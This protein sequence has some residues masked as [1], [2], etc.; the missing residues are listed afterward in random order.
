M[1]QPPSR[2]LAVLALILSFVPVCWIAQ[3]AAIVMAVIHLAKPRERTGARRLAVAAIPIAIIMG[4]AQLGVLILIGFAASH[5]QAHR[6]A[7]GAVTQA[8]FVYLDELHIGDCAEKPAAS[9]TA[10]LKVVPCTTPHTLEV[11]ATFD[12]PPGPY[13]GDDDVKR[14]AHGGC[15]E[16]FAAYVGVTADKTSVGYL[17]YHPTST[18]WGGGRNVQCLLESDA[19]VTHSLKGAGA[20]P[21]PTN[22][23]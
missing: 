6:D 16:R 11:F 21:A 4:L 15:G 18:S 5:D 13:P 9:H 22:S 14:F 10:R 19:P 12:L 3:V 17:Y 2:T 20:G 7:A 1:A 8:G 23:V